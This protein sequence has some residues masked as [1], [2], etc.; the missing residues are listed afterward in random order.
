MSSG[1][2]VVALDCL[3]IETLD[4]FYN[5]NHETAKGKRRSKL[6]FWRKFDDP[7]VAA[8]HAVFQRSPVLNSIFDTTA[9]TKVF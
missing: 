2:A 3:L 7:H 4:Q 6:F 8:F 1:F 5:G 9:K